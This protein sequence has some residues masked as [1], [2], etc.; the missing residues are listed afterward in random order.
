MAYAAQHCFAI[1]TASV[2]C[3]MEVDEDDFDDDG[4]KDEINYNLLPGRMTRNKLAE[5]LFNL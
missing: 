2:R 1:E 3:W 5:R 4:A